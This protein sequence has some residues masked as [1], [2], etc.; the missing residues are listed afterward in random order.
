V[1]G[2]IVVQASRPRHK[3]NQ[4]DGFSGV[5]RENDDTFS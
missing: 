3:K 4:T 1:T 2:A 5:H